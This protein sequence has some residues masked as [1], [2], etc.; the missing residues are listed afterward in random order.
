MEAR[1]TASVRNA[2]RPRAFE[3]AGIAAEDGQK[4]LSDSFR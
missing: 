4:L 2:A 3:A 1:R